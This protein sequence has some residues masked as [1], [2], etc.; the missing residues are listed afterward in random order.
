VMI[1]RLW[2]QTGGCGGDRGVV[3]ANERLW[4]CSK[5]HGGEREVVVVFERL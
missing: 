5:G 4:W 3:G 1:E 2:V